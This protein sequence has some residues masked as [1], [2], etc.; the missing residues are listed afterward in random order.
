MNDKSRKKNSKI[1][2]ALVLQGGG[3]LG[4]YEAGVVN[5]LYHWIKKD[6]K[7]KDNENIF[8]IIAGTSIGAINAAILVSHSKESKSLNEP[9]KQLLKFW[10]YLSSNN[11]VNELLTQYGTLYWDGVRMLFP[12]FKLPSSE[13]I[14]R[15][16]Y[17]GV[18]NSIGQTHVFMPKFFSPIPT[19][20]YN[21]FYDF[22]PLSSWWYQYDKEPLKRSIK[23][24]A[25]FPIS[26]NKDNIN[27]NDSSIL[28]P[29]LLLVSVDIDEGATVTFD[30][31]PYIGKEC[32]ICKLAK[33]DNLSKYHNNVSNNENNDNKFKNYQ[34]LLDHVDKKHRQ[35]YSYRSMKKGSDI[36]WSVYDSNSKYIFYNGIEPEHVIASAS[37]PK[38][39]N[40][41]I[42]DGHKFWDGGILSNTPLRE[43]ISHHITWWSDKLELEY[44][45][46]KMNLSFENWNEFKDNIKIPD[47][48]LYIVN[49]HPT[50]EGSEENGE[51]NIGADDYDMIKD[52]ENDIRF[53]DKTEYD[54]KVATLVTDYITCIDKLGNLA[55]E[56][57]GESSNSAYL[58]GKFNEL[59]KEKGLSAKRTGERRTYDDLIKNR[60]NLEVKF[61]IE[62]RDDIDTISN[63]IFDFSSATISHL[64]NEGIDDALNYLVKN[65]KENSNEDV[66]EQLV[67]FIKDIKEPI[68]EEEKHMV[69]SANKFLK[70]L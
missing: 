51:Y 14:R 12:F 59:L 4:A 42:I 29:R 23:E 36:Y 45:F 40:F 13:S 67:K 56:A 47:L 31:Y 50:K 5:V 61:K 62:R 46:D 27:K 16:L 66:H 17:T 15:Y 37:I 22:F 53:H 63:K 54:Q 35:N 24:F 6:L 41:E 21:K 8:D 39:Y 33:L 49:L 52:R 19:R 20:M 48:E 43:L 69:H 1:Q 65:Y 26:T 3:S 34:E 57:I 25:K 28:E 64:I 55:I 7:D 18:S 44:G 11:S 58:I 38:N 30:S 68:T 2:R 10:K 9:P 32:Q 70:T 60:F